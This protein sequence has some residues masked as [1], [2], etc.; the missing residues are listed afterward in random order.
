M[1]TTINLATGPGIP[2]ETSRIFTPLGIRFWDLTQNLPVSDGLQVNL[3]LMNSQAPPLYAVTTSSGVYAFF[4]LPG[5]RA[6][7]YRDGSGQLGS[8]P[9]TFSYVVTV[10]DNLG[11]YLPQV[12]IYTLDQ[13]GAVLVN[14][15]PDTTRGA[16]L[17]Y[18]FSAPGRPAPPGV[19]A[20]RAWLVEQKPDGT[21]APAAWAVMRV[22]VTGQAEIWPGIADDSGRV[23]VLVPYPLLDRLKLGSPPG[24]GQGNISGESWP[25]TV[26]VQYSPAAFSFPL[27]NVQGLSWPFTLTPNLKNILEDQ[28]AA[29]IWA[30]PATPVTKFSASL[31]LGRELV[32]RSAAL[33]PPA[34][35]PSL[36]ISQGTSP[37]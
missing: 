13:S 19:A 32:L 16:R 15:V 27:A 4:G 3:R 11:R 25:V 35:V 8:P 33:S 21:T 36:N 23:L 12:L 5:L 31:N 20:V 22:Q 24:S 29:T 9:R 18:L 26:T 7:E 17:A 6:A 10:Q 34:L 30:D 14:G 28:K 1:G 2:L 37:P